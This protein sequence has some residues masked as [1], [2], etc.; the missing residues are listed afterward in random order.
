MASMKQEYTG[1]GNVQ[2][3]QICTFATNHF[4]MEH[5]LDKITFLVGRKV[6]N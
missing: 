5:E 6:Y 4:D 1:K 2:D 3:V